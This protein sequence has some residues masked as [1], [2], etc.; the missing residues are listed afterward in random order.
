MNPGR[1]TVEVVFPLP[2]RQGLVKLDLPQG[3]TVRDALLAYRST[4]PNAPE[5][6]AAVPAEPTVARYG[7]LLALN[8]SLSDGDRLDIL[9]PLV[10]DPKEA[11]RRRAALHAGKKLQR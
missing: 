2:E 11:R 5:S 1:I 8:D 9:R 10:V 6:A 4:A 3:A 7:H